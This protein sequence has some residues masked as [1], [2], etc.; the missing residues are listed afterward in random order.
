M[1]LQWGRPG[2]C[3]GRLN[4]EIRVYD[5][6]DKWK[7]PYLRADHEPAMTMEA[8]RQIDSAIGAHICK[9]L[10]LCNRQHTAFYLLLLPGEKV[11]KTAVLSKQLGSSR[12]S[13]ADSA[14]MEQY[15]DITPGSL[16]VMGLMN[17][18]GHRVQLL[19]DRDLL[20]EEFFACHPCINTSTLRMET[21]ALLKTLLPAL[22]CQPQ[23]V[24]LES[25]VQVSPQ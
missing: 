6:L 10:L 4:K 22:D 12:L 13:F 3:T 7:I 23:F 1:V 5:F 21:G 20:K 18:R 11:F 24:T 2:D 17:D 19:I 15:L 25:P 14:Y 8:C 16:S 9:N